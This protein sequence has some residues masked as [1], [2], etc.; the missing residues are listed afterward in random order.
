MHRTHNPTAPAADTDNAL[1]VTPADILRGAARYLETHGWTQA[2][3]YGGTAD[4]AFPPACADGAIGMA[5]YGYCPLV[6]GD[7]HTDPGF[8]DYKRAL[9]HLMDYLDQV[10]EPPPGA[11]LLWDTD[12]IDQGTN[13]FAWNDR[14]DQS[15]EQVIATLRAAADDYHR[16]HAT[17][18][19]HHIIE[20]PLLDSGG[21]LACGCH[22]SQRDH[23]CGPL[24]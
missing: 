18:L 1:V 11:P 10:E 7:N 19:D 8:R 16:T 22:G 3:Y 4:D 20:D 12:V 5:A 13:P 15:A 2:V 9:D 24:D 23:T 14:D 6:P 21:H 17:N